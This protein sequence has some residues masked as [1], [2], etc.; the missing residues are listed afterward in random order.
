ME[1]RKRHG[2]KINSDYFRINLL[3]SLLFKRKRSE[4]EAS[5]LSEAIIEA[6]DKIVI[7]PSVIEEIQKENEVH[8]NQEAEKPPRGQK[9]KLESIESPI[10]KKLRRFLRL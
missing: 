7:I 1:N 10:A 6:F 3:R 8:K 9:R 4:Q 5:I 2:R